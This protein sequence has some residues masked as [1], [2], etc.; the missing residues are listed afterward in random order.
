MNAELR[1]KLAEDFHVSIG[2]EIIIPAGVEWKSTHP[3]RDRG[4]TKREMRLKAMTVSGRWTPDFTWAGTGGYW[5][6]VKKTDCF[7]PVSIPVK[8]LEP[9]A[10]PNP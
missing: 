10:T 9:I 3:T 8:P 1:E 5:R 2:T 6:W 4:V 7:R